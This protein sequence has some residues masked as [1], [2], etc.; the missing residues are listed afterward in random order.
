MQNDWILI[1]ATM[2]IL[3]AGTFLI[4]RMRQPL[5]AYI[6]MVAAMLLCLLIWMVPN[7]SRL[8]PK[9]I[10]SILAAYTLLRNFAQIRGKKE[11]TQQE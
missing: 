1:I 7:E 10:L 8:W 11:T 4:G 9:L 3:L 2:A 5:Q 6:R